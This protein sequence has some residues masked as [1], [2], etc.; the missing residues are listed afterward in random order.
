MAVTWGKKKVKRNRLLSGEYFNVPT[1]HGPIGIQ[2][3]V[4]LEFTCR[5]GTH[6]RDEGAGCA[7]GWPDV[8][9]ELNERLDEVAERCVSILSQASPKGA[10]AER[11]C[12]I[13]LFEGMEG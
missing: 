12:Q 4:N 13:E 7:D 2:M 9:R 5:L 3:E 8:E 6:N 1:A 10:S 11:I